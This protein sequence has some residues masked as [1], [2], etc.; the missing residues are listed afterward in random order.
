MS[1]GRDSQE[2]IHELARELVPLIGELIEHPEASGDAEVGT[3]QT[4]DLVHVPNTRELAH[5]N[6]GTTGSESVPHTTTGN[7]V[8]S[9][10]CRDKVAPKQLPQGRERR[11]LLEGVCS[12]QLI[13]PDRNSSLLTVIG[14]ETEE[15]GYED[16]NL[17]MV[18]FNEAPGI[19]HSLSMLLY[20]EPSGAGEVWIEEILNSDDQSD[21]DGETPYHTA[22]PPGIQTEPPI[23]EEPGGIPYHLE[24]I[25]SYSGTAIDQPLKSWSH[26]PSSPELSYASYE[27]NKGYEDLPDTSQTS[28]HDDATSQEHTDESANASTKGSE[29][30][31][32]PEPNSDS[33]AH[34][35]TPRRHAKPLLGRR[36]TKSGRVRKISYRMKELLRE[37]VFDPNTGT[38]SEIDELDAPA[39]K[40]FR[41]ALIAVALMT[42]RSQA[43]QLFTGSEK[44]GWLGAARSELNSLIEKGVFEE[45]NPEDV[46]KDRKIIP[47]H[48]VLT[49]KY[50]ADGHFKKYKARMICQGFR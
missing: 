38:D 36:K 44:K 12:Q 20:G 6:V 8:E 42:H 9:S 29:T 15:H 25:S 17:S 34:H 23:V 31:P 11:K 24:P 33:L 3:V 41:Q 2:L 43:M 39:V 35:T 22:S 27:N 46:A 45:V 32:A 19:D 30:V 40:Q 14:N 48:W 4:S 10:R 50:D 28:Q 13:L 49:K 37:S 18:P 26:E 1:V 5:E 47:M 7:A 21:D 16:T